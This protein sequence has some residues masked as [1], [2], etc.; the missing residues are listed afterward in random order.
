MPWK[1][2]VTGKTGNAIGSSGYITIVE[3]CEED[4][5]LGVNNRELS[6]SELEASD[7]KVTIDITSSREFNSVGV[8]VYLK[9]GLEYDKVKGMHPTV[10]NSSGSTVANGNFVFMPFAY[11]PVPLETVTPGK[12]AEMSVKVPETAKPG[13]R[14]EI[15]V[16]GEDSDGTPMPWKDGVTGKTGNAIGSSGYITIVEDSFTL[17]I[18]DK[19]VTMDELK[20][21][22]YMVTV[23]LI[24][25]G[26]VNSF[27][28]GVYLYDG[29]EYDDM[30]PTVAKAQES[31]VA[32]GNFVYMPFSYK[33]VPLKTLAAGK[34]GEL[35][36]KVPETA[37]P[38]D[39]FKIQVTGADSKGEL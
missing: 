22:D 5:V 6:L 7:Y 30:Y 14:F 18:N 19:E 12:F 36:V 3:E 29:L 31:S 27:G 37:K 16:T 26:D 39:C 4:L 17:G 38:G 10:K 28:M 33:P 35:T 34:F 23:D 11:A 2:G 8:G 20:S 13:D 9:D 15:Q 24:S 32:N 21:S 25:N 1:D